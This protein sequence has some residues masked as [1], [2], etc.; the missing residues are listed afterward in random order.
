MTAA[1]VLGNQEGRFAPKAR[2]DGNASWELERAPAWLELRLVWHTEGKGSTEAMVIGRQ[3]L[4][5]VGARGQRSFAFELAEMPY[6]YH[7]RIVSI[8]WSVDMFA[9]APPLWLRGKR[10]A[11]VP[12]IVSPTLQPYGERRA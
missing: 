9:G 5:D 7:G 12:I 6:T 10:I 3:R 8:L 1:I 4:A 11:T 2:V